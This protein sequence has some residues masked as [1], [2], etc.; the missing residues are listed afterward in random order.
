M[1]DSPEAKD[2]Q[3]SAKVLKRR[4]P[5][6]TQNQEASKQAAR[7][8]KRRKLNLLLIPLLLQTHVQHVC[9]LFLSPFCSFSFLHLEMMIMMIL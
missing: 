1:L 9:D 7:S 8:M 3:V 2:F 5:P 6:F 4:R